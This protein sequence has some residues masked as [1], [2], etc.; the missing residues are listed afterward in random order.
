MSAAPATTPAGLL[1]VARAAARAGADVLGERWAGHHPAVPLT[2]GQLGADTKS[3][4]SDWVTDYDRRAEDAVR[5]VLVGYR[6]HDE[7]TGEEH[8]ATVPAE[9]SGYRWSIDPLDGTTNF[10]CGLPQFCTSVAVAGPLDAATAAA[11]RERGAPAREGEERWLA[12]AVVAPGLGRTW[13]AS[14]D[15]GAFSTVDASTAG[16]H[17]PDRGAPV[18]L[19]GPVPGRSGRLLATGFGYQPERR[20][21][22]LDALE[23]L[24]PGFGDVR[25]IGSA[26]LDL[27]MVADGTL[28]AYAEYGTQEYD[29]A[30]GALIAEEA[31]VPVTRPASGD[32]TAHPDWMVAGDVDP[33]ALARAREAVA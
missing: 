27:C 8:G 5:R 1:V 7:L 10:I 31:G 17:A 13:Y 22:Q 19:T 16:V 20:R 21:L 11:L 29:W 9:P 33:A 26:A 14:A 4:G 28:D 24:L 2:Q 15:G 12:G 23:A 6:P 30:A 32:G 3:S 25:R 18:P